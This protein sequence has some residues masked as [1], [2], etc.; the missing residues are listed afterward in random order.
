MSDPLSISASVTALVTAG[1]AVTTGLVDFY[2]ANRDRDSNI[3]GT[4]AKLQGLLSVF[5]SLKETLSSRKF[6]PDE[7]SLI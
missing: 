6:Q 4:T 3:G 1:I 7:Q 2:I 5:K